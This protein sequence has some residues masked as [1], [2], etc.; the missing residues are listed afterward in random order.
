MDDSGDWRTPTVFDVGSGSCDGPCCRDTAEQSGS[1]VSD[2]LSGQ[3]H[4]RTMLFSNH[5]VSYNA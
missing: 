5:T 1:N 4:I 3:L 2:S